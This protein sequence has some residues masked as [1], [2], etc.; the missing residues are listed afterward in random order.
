M[1]TARSGFTDNHRQNLTTQ[2][3]QGSFHRNLNKTSE[4]TIKTRS[5][6][7]YDAFSLAFSSDSRILA[8]PT[9]KE[10]IK[11]WDVATG[12]EICT[13]PG[14]PSS[15]W[16]NRRRFS[17]SSIAFSRYGNV[18]VSGGEDGTIKVWQQKRSD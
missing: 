8:N 12:D 18:L 4:G 6:C 9:R 5:P 3:C 16:Y 13:L 7:R 15:R 1:Q 2:R 11:L 17:S 14:H 10:T